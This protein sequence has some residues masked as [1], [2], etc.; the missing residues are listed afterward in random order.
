MHGFE[1]ILGALDVALERIG[2][3][4]LDAAARSRHAL[5][6]E[7]DQEVGKPALDGAE[8]IEARVGGVELLDQPHDPVFEIVDRGL[9]GAAAV[10]LIDLVGEA[11]HHRF[12]AGGIADRHAA[13]LLQ[14][15]RDR[16]DPL[17]DER[18]RIG[19]R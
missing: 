8:M 15:V 4:V 9:I 18:K 16:R 19:R 12:E 13:R 1:R 5:A 11:S 14:R 17:L 10:E 7:V 2:F 3:G 6:F